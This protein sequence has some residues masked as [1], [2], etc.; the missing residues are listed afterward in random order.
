MLKKIST[1]LMKYKIKRTTLLKIITLLI[2]AS[3]LNNYYY[4]IYKYA[5]NLPLADD[6][7]SILSFLNT[8]EDSNSKIITLF[9]QHNEHRLVFLRIIVLIYYKLFSSINF[10]HLILL[11]NFLFILLLVTLYNSTN[12][13]RKFILISPVFFLI[14]NSSFCETQTWAMGS[15]SNYP[16]LIFAFLS[17][18]LIN[19]SEIGYFCLGIFFALL[20]SFSQGN[21]MFVFFSGVLVLLRNRP[22]LISWVLI[23][24]ITIFTYFI[25]FPYQKPDA[26]PTVLIRFEKLFLI[27]RIFYAL[28]LL[29]SVFQSKII[30]VVGV[31]PL[32]FIL[33]IFKNHKQFSRLHLS[34]LSFVLISFVSLII[35][36]DRFGYGQA[37]ASRYQLN[38]V[39]LYAVIY[40]CFLPNIRIR[41]HLALI[42][43]L[44][45]LFNLNINMQS[46]DDF[47]NRKVEILEDQICK[48]KCSHY[49]SYPNDIRAAEVLSASMAKGI[50]TSS[51][52]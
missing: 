25:L 27:N 45:G 26:Y 42:L 15:L 43:L 52:K 16:V 36:R 33:Y 29:S 5:V 3:T 47:Y 24:L 49:K 46:K 22:R 35:S 6:Y 10:V 12:D 13:K 50:F 7:D 30:L 21:G 39:I 41:K 14:L 23:G 48:N 9:S 17:L 38:T 4:A 34:M 2:I 8:W 20:S 37:F 31:I 11:G 40:L 32:L 44:S 18:Y 1:I 28:T 19:R 51:S